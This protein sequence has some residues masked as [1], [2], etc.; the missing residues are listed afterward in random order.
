MT[1]FEAGRTY[2]IKLNGKKQWFIVQRI[3]QKTWTATSFTHMDAEGYM[4]NSIAL[5]AE[6]MNIGVERIS[7]CRTEVELRTQMFGILKYGR[8]TDEN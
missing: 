5:C 4:G 3:S 1:K 7:M 2:L 6:L 8:L